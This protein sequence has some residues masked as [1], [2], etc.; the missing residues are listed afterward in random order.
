MLFSVAFSPGG[1]R[2][3]SGSGDRT[4]ELWDAASGECLRTLKGRLG[5]VGSV[6]FSPD[7]KTLA[8][9]S[10]GETAKLASK[11]KHAKSR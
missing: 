10:E 7:G 6:V 11:P 2:I 4:V 9:G 8:S 3:A 5:G 1:T